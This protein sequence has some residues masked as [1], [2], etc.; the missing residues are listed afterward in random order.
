MQIII[1]RNRRKI[2]Y[3][4]L[5]LKTQN[6]HLIKEIGMIP[7]YFSRL[8]NFSGKIITY[9][10]GDY[11]FL[12]TFC[13]GVQLQFI[14][15]AKRYNKIIERNVLKYLLFNA[16]KIDFLNLTHYTD[17]VPIFG[18]FY[19]LLNK[20]G[21][22]YLKLDVHE[23]FKKVDLYQ[24]NYRKVPY[25]GFLKILY[26][27]LRIQLYKVFLK[28]VDLISVENKALVAFF[29]K[30]YPELKNKFIYIPNGID[31]Y[32]FKNCGISKIPFHERENIIL[33]VCRIGTI[34]KI[35]E[36]LMYAIA[37]LDDLKDWKVLYIGPIDKS[38]YKI[39]EKF[40]KT[41][42]HLKEKIE[43]IGE[44]SDRK[45]LYE[46]YQKCKIFCLTT[47]YGSFEIVLVEALTNGCYLVSSNIPSAIDITNNGTLGT[48]YQHGNEDDLAKKLQ[49]VINY[50]EFIEQLYP[51]MLKFAENNF[52]WSKIIKK[53]YIE[54]LKRI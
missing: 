18:V 46:F 2:N 49:K 31:D 29:K 38:F 20:K 45:K 6:I 14:K 10:N 33:N 26:F 39:C 48:I 43:F 42:P 22:L 16:K 34:G 11:P 53:L 47:F 30:K 9:N 12:K 35:S 25:K 37:K 36:I 54:F 50:D 8:F 24:R 32:Y 3:A 28:K 4:I 1:A 17:E 27:Y 40:F 23:Y 21:F 52:Y 7:T 51:K 41:Y 5:F 13:P 44:V 15:K 19:K